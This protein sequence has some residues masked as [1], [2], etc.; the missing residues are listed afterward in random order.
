MGA[1]NS[2]PPGRGLN[3]YTLFGCLSLVWRFVLPCIFPFTLFAMLFILVKYA[4]D[5]VLDKYDNYKS[6][7][8]LSIFAMNCVLV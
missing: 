3:Y 4:S 6:H 5:R 8:R 1:K 7:Y 2:P